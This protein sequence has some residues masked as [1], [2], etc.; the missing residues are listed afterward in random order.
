MFLVALPDGPE[1]I[2]LEEHLPVKA[3]A[4]HYGYNQ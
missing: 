2:V 1:G 3:A 4:E